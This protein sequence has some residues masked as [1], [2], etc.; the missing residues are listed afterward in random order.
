M[1]IVVQR[2]SLEPRESLLTIGGI[3]QMAVRLRVTTHLDS[4]PYGLQGGV[5]VHRLCSLSK[6]WLSCNKSTC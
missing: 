2:G 1:I 5:L 4:V 6:R 3:S